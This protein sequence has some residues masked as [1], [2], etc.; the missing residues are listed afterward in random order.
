MGC[1]E[2]RGENAQA[3]TWIFVLLGRKNALAE[4]KKLLC[5]DKKLKLGRRV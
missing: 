5:R 2:K 3:E 4:G 1:E